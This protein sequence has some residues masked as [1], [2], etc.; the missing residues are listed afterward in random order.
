MKIAIPLDENK[1]NVC[2]SFGRAP[3]FLFRENGT[4]EILENP[5][6]DAEGG[7]GIEAAQ[8]VVDHRA[9]VLITVRCGQNAADVFRAAGMKIYKSQGDAAEQN[10]KLFEEGRLEE[11][12]HFHAG[13][14]GLR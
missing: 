7:A 13:Y 1:K 11:L 8:F 12:T 9:E 5:G 2:I 4:D 10:L 14:Q 6:A 3:Y